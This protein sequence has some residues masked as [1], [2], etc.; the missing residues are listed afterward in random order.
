MKVNTGLHDLIWLYIYILSLKNSVNRKFPTL[1]KIQCQLVQK[2]YIKNKSQNQQ[3]ENI[4][5][6]AVTQPS[7]HSSM[8]P[9]I[10]YIYRMHNFRWT[11]KGVHHRSENISHWHNK[12]LSRLWWHSPGMRVKY[13][14]RKLHL[15][16]YTLYFTPQAKWE[17]VQVTWDSAAASV[18]GLFPVPT[19]NS[20]V[21]WFWASLCFRS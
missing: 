7:A 3:Y 6:T 10:Y 21:S 2:T 16:Y 1:W 20:L 18:C 4:R 13:Q 15:G 12:D 17:L 14:V 19:I 11:S 9:Y 5:I 8:Q